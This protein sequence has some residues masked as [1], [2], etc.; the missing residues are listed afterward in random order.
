MGTPREDL[1][2]KLRQARLAAG[3][4]SHGALAKKL[5]V[6]RSVITKAESATHPVPSDALLTAWAGVTDV[7]AEPL[8]DLAQRVKSGNPE[9][10]MPFRIAEAEADILRYW[11]PN[12]VP[13]V[14]QTEG[15]ARAVLGVESYT[16]E[17]L[18]ELVAARMER[19]TV[20][21]RAHVTAIIDQHV[22]QRPIGSPAIM[23]EQCAYLAAM[24]ERADIALHVIP[25]GTNMGLWGAFDLATRGSLITVCL[26]AIEDIPSTAGGLV[27][28]T[29]LAFEELLGAALPRG[30]SLNLIV[31]AVERWKQQI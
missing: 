6:S 8:L 19:Q 21:G 20:I 11:Q 16:V 25:E 29:T 26:G 13:G 24:A 4:G 17:R 5:N 28:K 12:L 22:T 18:N 27:S 1:G 7:P 31:E 2:N 9:W 30:A 14:L 15:Y 23:A 3:Y 10:F